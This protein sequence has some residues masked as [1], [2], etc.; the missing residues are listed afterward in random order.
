MTV[1]DLKA[2]EE[3]RKKVQVAAKEKAKI[4]RI[5][6][7][8]SKEHSYFLRPESPVPSSPEVLPLSSNIYLEAIAA[9]NLDFTSATLGESIPIPDLGDPAVRSFTLHPGTK[10]PSTILGYPEDFPSSSQGYMPHSTTH[11]K[12]SMDPM[13]STYSDVL[14]IPSLGL[15][16]LSSQ[17]SYI[18]VPNV[19]VQLPSGEKVRICIDFFFF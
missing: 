1:G 18:D 3:V 15:D 5:N 10:L 13:L 9:A 19:F 8:T 11:D 7:I 2:Q 17:T 12:L 4:E 16:T 6:R 14:Q